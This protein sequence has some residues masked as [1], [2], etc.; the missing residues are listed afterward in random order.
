MTHLSGS[1]NRRPFRTIRRSS[2]YTERS[3]IAAIGACIV[4]AVTSGLAPTSAAGADQPSADRAV[5][6]QGEIARADL[7]NKLEVTLGSAF[8][9]VWF[10]AAAA[11]L[12]VGVTSADSRRTAEQVVAQAGLAGHVTATPVRSSS[13]ELIATQQLWN[14]KLA[15][16]FAREQ[17]TT[18]LEPQ[19]NGVSIRL[20]SSVP[21]AER[22]ALVGAAASAPVNV[23]VS[24]VSSPRIGLLPQ[25]KTSCIEWVTFE[26][27]CDP[28]LTSGVS[29][30][31]KKK[32]ECTVGPLAINSKNET[33]A[34]TAGHCIAEAKEKWSAKNGAALES[35]VGPVEEFVFG[36]AGAKSG[37]FADVLIEAGW[38]T[39][40]PNNPVF[41]VTAEWKRMN[42]AGEKTS[43]PVKGKRTPTVGNQ[44]CHVGQTSGESCGEITAD[45]LTVTFG[46]IKV[47]GLVEVKE[48]AMPVEQLIGEGG[49][50]GGPWMFIETNKETL[51]EGTHTGILTTPE[52]ALVAVE[53]EGRQF[54][55]K[56]NECKELAF[57]EKA[58]N[59]GKWQRK[60]LLLFYP[61]VKTLAGTPEGSLEQ[62]N[63]TLLTTANEVRAPAIKALPGEAFPVTFKVTSGETKIETVGKSSIICTADEG[64]G[65]FGNGASGT[66]SVDFT[67]CKT[68]KVACRSETAKGEKDPVETILEV[69]AKLSVINILNAKKELEGGVVKTLAEPIKVLC[70]AVKVEVRGSVVGLVTPINKEV[71][72]TE[73]A[74]IEYKQKEGKQEAGECKEPKE[75][76]EKLTKEPFEANIVGKFEAAGAQATET[77]SFSKMVELAA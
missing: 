75:V 19:R 41:A 60:L 44:T 5:E 76:C 34:L 27:Y 67:G 35:V 47:E 6:V 40:K 52:C 23:F 39:G 22:A 21:A 45:N 74:K 46:A 17:V 56:E 29:F 33:V 58:G 26:A 9:G 4:L 51:M 50:S 28:S 10:D 66:I 72:T 64:S 38:Q 73:T 3:A 69:N 42:N 13:A 65:E 53:T 49:D 7:L 37:D 24:V 16:L 8:G 36:V 15:S 57:K 30:L 18:A 55:A 54:F 43:Y 14:R 2:Y 48:P 63:L 70:G 32:P 20:S 25:A 1:A 59:K 12:H 61:L 62:L 11:T 71:L 77:T 68:G 31:T